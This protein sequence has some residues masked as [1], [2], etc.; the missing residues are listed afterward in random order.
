MKIKTSLFITIF[1][2]LLILAASANAQRGMGETKGM[3]QKAIQPAIKTISG[4]I[5]E[6]RTGPCGNTTGRSSMGTHLIVQGDKTKLN[7]HLGPQS[8]V[9]HV[10]NQLSI[11]SLVTFDV[12]RTEKMPENAYV[13]KT[14]IFNDK[15]IHLRDHNLRPT[16]ACGRG[17]VQGKGKGRGKK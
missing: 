4:K 8:E 6:I 17:N 5:L 3:S 10:V 15:I 14:L 13:A 11:G 9:D 12:F 1:A 7:I 16:W 2:A